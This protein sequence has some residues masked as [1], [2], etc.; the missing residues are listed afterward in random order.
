MDGNSTT[1]ASA[2]PLLM[3]GIVVAV[4]LLAALFYPTAGHPA[5][6]LSLTGRP[7]AAAIAWGR[8]NDASLVG[9][10][11]NGQAAVLRLSAASSPLAALR[12]G[13]LPLSADNG[14]CSPKGTVS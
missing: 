14:L 1:P 4:A 7:P 2:L 8:H 9:L 13:F 6:L 10:S 5:V 12:S 3:Q 11:A